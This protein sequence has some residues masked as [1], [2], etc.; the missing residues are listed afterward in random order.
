MGVKPSTK[1]IKGVKPV[2]GDTTTSASVDRSGRALFVWDACPDCGTERWIKLNTQGSLCVSCA[3]RRGASGG[4]SRRWK[5]GRRFAK[6]GIFLTIQPDHP[7]IAMANKIGK[8]YQIAEHRLAMAQ[9]LGRCLD[10]WEIVHHINRDNYDNRLENLLLL[11]NQTQHHSYTLL[12]ARVGKL[13]SRI[14]VLEAEVSLLQ[15]QLLCDKVVGN[16]ELAG[17]SNEESQDDPPGKC[18]GYTP[19]TPLG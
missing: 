14:V 6:N 5:G 19:P 2:V 1:W 9:H 8:T 13:E 16:P 7:F 12:Q 17:G 15:S 18:R 10:T 11:P 4:N 3:T